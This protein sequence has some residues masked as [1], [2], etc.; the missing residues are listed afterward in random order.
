[1]DVRGEALVGERGGDE[2]GAGF[3]LGEDDLLQGAVAEVDVAGLAV[4][5][6]AERD[7]E[8]R[9]GPGAGSLDLDGLLLVD[10]LARRLLQLQ[11][12]RVGEREL[13]VIGIGRLE[14]GCSVDKDRAL[15]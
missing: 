6:V 7:G 15:C 2:L 5:D 10:G 13:G 1:V 9:Q 11:V 14:V 4:L 8:G 3:G 12:A